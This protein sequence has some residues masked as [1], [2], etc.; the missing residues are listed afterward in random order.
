MPR[1]AATV[2]VALMVFTTLCGTFAWSSGVEYTVNRGIRHPAFYLAVFVV[3]CGFVIR[4]KQVGWLF[5]LLYFAM[6]WL[7]IVI[8]VFFKNESPPLLQC[9]FMGGALGTGLFCLKYRIHFD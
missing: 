2:L 7:G 8:L 6:E 1:S 3:L 4:Q 9:L 5:M